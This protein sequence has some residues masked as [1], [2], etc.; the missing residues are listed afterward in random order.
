MDNQQ[1]KKGLLSALISSPGSKGGAAP[2]LRRALFSSE[3]IR[4]IFFFFFKFNYSYP[5]L[6]QLSLSQAF[7]ILLTITITL[8]SHIVVVVQ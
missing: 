5:Y 8:T 6:Q 7:T 3:T 1:E 2:L 4:L